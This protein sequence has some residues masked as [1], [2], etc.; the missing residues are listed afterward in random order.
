MHKV[1]YK[2]WSFDYI[3][4]QRVDELFEKL[5]KKQF[6]KVGNSI[7]DTYDVKCIVEVSEDEEIIFNS[8]KNE[9][10]YINKKVREEISK[11]PYDI[12]PWIVKN[13]ILKYK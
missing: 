4:S 7:R 13:M 3:D 12:T 6:I 10:E 9:N 11:Y 1:I 5:N 2:W 8:L